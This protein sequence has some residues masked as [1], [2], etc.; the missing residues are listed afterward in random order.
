MSCPSITDERR[1]WSWG[2]PSCLESN[3]RD[4][5]NCPWD[6]QIAEGIHKI[7]GKDAGGYCVGDFILKKDRYRTKCFKSNYPTDYT[8]KINCCS[9]KTSAL[10]CDINYCR[11]ST[12]CQSIMKDYCRGDKLSSEECQTWKKDNPNDYDTA[13][14]QYCKTENALND[15][16][17]RDWCKKT[18]QCD[19]IVSHWCDQ[20][21]E[22]PFCSCIKSP[23]KNP[24]CGYGDDKTCQIQGYQT[25]SQAD[26]IAQGG[27]PTHFD[28]R[29]ELKVDGSYNKMSNDLLQQCAEQIST[30]TLS[31]FTIPGT[32]IVLDIYQFVLLVLFILVTIIV[33]IF[34][35][36]E[37]ND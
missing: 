35:Q 16:I 23:I 33:V 11:G 30:Y 4:L 25:Q 29:Q 37:N 12:A 13:L 5:S 32:S 9:G 17:C 27:C 7:S 14:V 2:A 26:M 19:T 6:K 15:P 36:A 8:A 34:K 31:S 24:Q 20:R 10:D 3:A 22:H 1:Q 28:C 18:H 21:P